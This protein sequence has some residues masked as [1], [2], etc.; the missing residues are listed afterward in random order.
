MTR[1]MRKC[2]RCGTDIQGR[3]FHLE[4][5]ALYVNMLFPKYSNRGRTE[6]V[7]FLEAVLAILGWL[8]LLDSAQQLRGVLDKEYLLSSVKRG[9]DLR[10]T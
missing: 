2:C 10:Q 1:Y 9:T 7:A 6:P 3:E 5:K 4:A 8:P